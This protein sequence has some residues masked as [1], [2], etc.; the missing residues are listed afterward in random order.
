M[1]DIWLTQWWLIQSVCKVSATVLGFSLDFGFFNFYHWHPKGHCIDRIILLLQSCCTRHFPF[2]EGGREGFSL[3]SIC[4]KSSRHSEWGA[5]AESSAHAKIQ[6]NPVWAPL[7]TRPSECES[8][9]TLCYVDNKD[10]DRFWSHPSLKAAW[11]VSQSW[12]KPPQQQRRKPAFSLSKR[13]QNCCP[14]QEFGVSLPLVPSQSSAERD[15]VSTGS[16]VNDQGNSAGKSNL[17]REEKILI[18]ICL[19]CANEWNAK[20]RKKKMMEER[21]HWW[22]NYSSSKRIMK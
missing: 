9:Y 20:E 18:A 5:A 15:P 12:L 4:M 13:G 3:L 19:C 21:P 7:W 16:L 14:G 2:W 17:F 1:L 8:L 6:W 11:A 22:K 10:K